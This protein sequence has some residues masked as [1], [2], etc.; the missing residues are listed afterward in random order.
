MGPAPRRREGAAASVR[1]FAQ[2][3]AAALAI[4]GAAAALAAPPAGTFSV[5]QAAPGG[6]F[7]AAW[8]I[9]SAD[10]ASTCVASAAPAN[11][12]WTGAKPLT[13]S[14]AVGGVAAGAVLTLTCSTA[15]NPTADLTWTAPT[16]NT[17]GSALTDLKDF[18]I[19]RGTAP[20]SLSATD[21]AGATA[22]AYTVAGLPAGAWYFAMTARN[23]AGVESA[24]TGPASTVIAPGEA[25]TFNATA[26]GVVT[27]KIPTGLV[28]K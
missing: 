19:Y 6:A 22:T 18:V 20:G 7:T 25:A 12:N 23:A 2:A 14:A 3:L 28:V 10:P 21:T 16:T 5:T 24:Q 17:D 1:R 4:A 26:I 13:G 27:P 9:T 8:A 11:S 15:G